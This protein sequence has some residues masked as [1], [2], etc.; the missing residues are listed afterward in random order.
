MGTRLYR[1]ACE[2]GVM[3]GWYDAVSQMRE[4]AP[5]AANP[6]AFEDAAAAEVLFEGHAPLSMKGLI[7]RLRGVGL[8]SIGITRCTCAAVGRGTNKGKRCHTATCPCRK[9]GKAC[10]SQCHKQG[11]CCNW[12]AEG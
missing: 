2:H 11:S 10:G 3:S 5:N 9:A 4:R 12:T 8:A 1:V 7:D 6:L